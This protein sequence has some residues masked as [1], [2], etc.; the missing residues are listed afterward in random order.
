[1]EL[2]LFQLV[3][4]GDETAFRSLFLRYYRLLSRYTAQITKNE[5]EAQ[6]LVDDVFLLLWEKRLSIQIGIS[7]RQYLYVMCRNKALRHLKN[8]RVARPVPLTPELTETLSQEPVDEYDNASA[9]TAWALS[10][11]DSLYQFIDKLPGKRQVIF[12]M[13]KLEGLSYH[14]IAGQLGVSEKTVKN[15]VFRAMQQLRQMS[16]ALFLIYVHRH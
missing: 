6:E 15:Q 3:R 2:V 8:T 7:V 4:Q 5:E 16:F 11:A 9:S 13:N 12:R 10:A 1:I 14:E